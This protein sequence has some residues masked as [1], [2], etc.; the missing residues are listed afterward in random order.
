MTNHINTIIIDDEF[1]ARNLIKYYLHD[2]SE[3]TIVG[4]AD[5]GFDALKKIKELKPKLIFLDI[6]MPKLTGFELLELLDNPPEIIF[7]T[8]YDQYAI[9]AFEQSAVD[10]LL[11]PY[12]KERFE[13]AIQKAIDKLHTGGTSQSNLQTLHE[14]MLH[15]A[16]KLTRIAVKKQQQIVV[17]NINDIQHIESYGDYV[18]LHT[19]NGSFLKEKTMKYFEENL[20]PEQF[21]RIHRCSIVNVDEIAKIELYEKESYRVHLKNGTI[22]KASATGYKMLKQSVKL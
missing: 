13:I 18:K 17:I 2:F 8:A 14:T 19:H 5:N 4:E 11:K 6:Q 15:H 7:S 12:S 9:R 1:S 3:I 21:S 22:L 20:P 16:E 10:Y